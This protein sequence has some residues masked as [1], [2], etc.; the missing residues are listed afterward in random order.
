MQDHRVMKQMAKA[1]WIII[2]GICLLMG[3]TD[4]DAPNSPTNDNP[5]AGI[6]MQAMIDAASAP[7]IQLPDADTPMGDQDVTMTVDAETPT[8]MTAEDMAIVDAEIIV[9]AAPIVDAE[10]PTPVIPCN[11]DIQFT[12]PTNLSFHRLS[13]PPT[14]RGT[15]LNDLGEGVAGLTVELT[16]ENDDVFATL[17]TNADGVFS[18]TAAPL[19]TQSGFRVIRALVRTES[20]IC[21]EYGRTS[22][23]V[24]ASSVDEDFSSRPD[25]W[26]LF[27]NASWDPNG[28]LEMTGTAMGQAGAAY[29]TVEVISSGLASIE[30]TV[31]TGGGQNGGADGFAFTI[32]EVA[33]SDQLLNLL[34]AAST[35]GGLG[36]GVGGAYQD[37][38]F[39]LNGDAITVEIDTWRNVD[40]GTTQRHT[41]PTEQNHIAITQNA[42]PGDHVA[43]FPVP[44]IED[45]QPHTIRLD[46]LDGSMRISFDGELVIEQDITFAFKGGYMFFSGS[47]GW[48]TNYHR[49]DD[50]RILHD[51]R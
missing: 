43:W 14:I 25:D 8:D 6:G 45:L 30:F 31:R 23:F 27:R 33:S 50:L 40:N 9:D 10:P 13:T 46:L 26:T 49:V 41:D 37:P 24:C 2:L 21:E 35:G 29:N 38:D 36:Y 11:L 18:S 34:N 28:W 48:A 20:E 4:N 1:S 39:T 7:D 3:C 47:T 51:C 15:V 32:V 19:H 22:M 12:S 5:D 44:N 17:Q 16:D 42:D